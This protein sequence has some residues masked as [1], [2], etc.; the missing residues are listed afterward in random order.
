[1]ANGLATRTPDAGN[2]RAIRELVA[3]VRLVSEAQ[4]L[5]VVRLLLLEEHVVGEPAGAATTAALEPAGDASGRAVVLLVTGANIA[6][7]VL[8]RA[9]C[10][11]FPTA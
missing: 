11:P 2:V 1:M 3:D 7:K 9:V 8:R 5:A 10:E 4:L 6:P